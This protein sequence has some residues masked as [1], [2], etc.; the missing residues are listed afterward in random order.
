MRMLEKGFD[1]L[2]LD[3]NC[4]LRGDTLALLA[5]IV[6][7][8]CIDILRKSYAIACRRCEARSVFPTFDKKDVEYYLNTICNIISWSP[9]AFVPS[10]HLPDSVEYDRLNNVRDRIVIKL[11]RRAGISLLGCNN[12]YMYAYIWRELVARISYELLQQCTLCQRANFM[13]AEGSIREPRDYSMRRISPPSFGEDYYTV[14]PQD[15]E[16]AATVLMLPVWAACIGTYDWCASK[17]A[18]ATKVT[19]NEI[20]RAE[21]HRELQKYTESVPHPFNEP[22]WQTDYEQDS[23]MELDGDTFDSDASV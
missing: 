1:E 15:I 20:I 21:R 2:V 5:W 10:E 11:C 23:E 6:Q 17:I 9:S 8:N 19:E 16:A 3:N 4:H 22:L 18:I 14:T 12:Q 7:D 13:A